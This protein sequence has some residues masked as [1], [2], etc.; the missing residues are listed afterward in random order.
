[1]F[2]GL[3]HASGVDSVHVVVVDQSAQDRF[4]SA[5]SPFGKKSSIVF[6]TVELAMHPI[7]QRLVDAIV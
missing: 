7:V 2:V 4:Y 6:I 5:A 1:M 3:W